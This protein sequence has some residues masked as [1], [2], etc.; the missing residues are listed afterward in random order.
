MHHVQG[1]TGDF[2][3]FLKNDSLR[4]LGA[5]LGAL[6]PLRPLW[7]P[8]RPSPSGVPSVPLWRSSLASVPLWR[9][10]PPSPSG[11]RNRG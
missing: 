2:F 10:A 5:P 3:Y 1:F 6:A 7:R 11:V 4:P 8:W 9:R